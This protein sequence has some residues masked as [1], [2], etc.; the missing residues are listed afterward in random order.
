M[1]LWPNIYI[2]NVQ[3]CSCFLYCIYYNVIWYKGRHFRT[4]RIDDKRFTQDC[5][6]IGPFDDENGFHDDYCGLLQNI[7]KLDYRRFSVYVFDVKWLK[8]IVVTCPQTSIKKCFDGFATID[9]TRFCNANKETFSMW[10]G[11]SS[12]P[13]LYFKIEHI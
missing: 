7:I 12:S 6:I 10:T 9:S 13:K 1:D 2:Y 11:T 5:G 3:Y 8:D 4:Q